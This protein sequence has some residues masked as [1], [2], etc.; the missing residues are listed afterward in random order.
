MLSTRS[1][2]RRNGR[3]TR[4]LLAEEKEHTRA[5]TSSPKA[6]ELPWVPVEKEYRFETDE[7]QVPAELFDGRSQL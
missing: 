4:R 3:P 1:E 5:A 7:G 2:L 6:A